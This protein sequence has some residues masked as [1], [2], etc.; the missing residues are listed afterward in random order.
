MNETSVAT[1]NVLDDHLSAW[2][3]LDLEEILV[4]YTDGSI[5]FTR[6]GV[7]RG[8]AEVKSLFEGFFE[9]SAKPG[10]SFDLHTKMVEGEVAYINWSAETADSVYEFATDTFVSKAAKKIRQSFVGKITPKKPGALKIQSGF[11]MLT[12]S[13]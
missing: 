12:N 7:V 10:A 5:M 1:A 4:D 11:P 9:E 13:S 8:R 6:S 2:G 3:A